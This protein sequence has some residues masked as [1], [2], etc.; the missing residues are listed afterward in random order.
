MFC[1]DF[2]QLDVTFTD[3][4]GP[5]SLRTE[6]Q[7]YIKIRSNSMVQIC[8][9]S[10]RHLSP[11]WLQ[12]SSWALLGRLL[13]GA[14]GRL[15]SIFEAFWSDFHAKIEPRWHLNAIISSSYVKTARQL[16]TII[17]LIDFFRFLRFRE[18]KIEG[19]IDLGVS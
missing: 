19:K 10:G 12:N 17:F 8:S 4:F 9:D 13:V 1:K 18:W 14:L 7:T 2:V 3:T 6:L 11:S 16:K 5:K 15:G